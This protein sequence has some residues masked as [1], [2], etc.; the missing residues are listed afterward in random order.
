MLAVM[1]IAIASMAIAAAPGTQRRPLSKQDPVSGMLRQHNQI[2]AIRKAQRPSIPSMA[3]KAPVFLASEVSYY[4]SL[5]EITCS[6]PVGYANV[7]SNIHADGGGALVGDTYYCIERVSG[8]ILTLS[9]YDAETWEQKKSVI[10]YG[11]GYFAHDMT[12]D[13][14]DNRI[15]GC[16]MK[17]DE[18]KTG[19][20]DADFVWGYLD[21]ENESR[22]ALADMDKSLAAVAADG[23]G[24]IYA[25]DYEGIL[26]QVNKADGSLTKLAET[27]LVS[28]LATGGVIDPKSG[29]M[30]YSTQTNTV[31]PKLYSIEISTGKTNLLG[32][33]DEW[34]QL[35]GMFFP[36]PK[37]SDNAPDAPTNLQFQFHGTALMGMVTFNMPSQTY[38]GD[39]LE[40][41]LTYNLSIDGE[42]KS[43]GTGYPGE[44]V[45]AFTEIESEGQH[46]VSV[47]VSNESGTSPAIEG[48]RWFGLDQLT[49]LRK[50]NVSDEGENVTISWNAPTAVHDGYFEPEFVTYDVTRLPD[51]VKIAED[52]TGTSVSDILTDDGK[53]RITTWRV[54]V[55][56]DGEIS[57]SATSDGVI[58]GSEAEIPFRTSF[59]T[60]EE[61][62]MF[63]VINA[64]DDN[65]KWQWSSFYDM[66]QCAVL[67][68]N[69]TLAGDDW[70]IT[71]ALRMQAGKKYKVRFTAS[72]YLEWCP[73]RIEV[74]WGTA[75]I[76]EGMKD[77]LVEPTVISHNKSEAT[78]TTAIF[79]PEEDG[80]YYIGF[81]GISDPYQFY[82]IV[83]DIA[84]TESNGM[85]PGVPTELSAKADPKGA[86]AVHMSFKTPSV[87]EAGGQLSL[88]TEAVV[89]RNDNVVKTFPMPAIGSMLEFDDTDV[90][91]GF[92]TYTVYCVNN[93][94]E[95]PAATT[96]T[97][98]G[99]DVP[100]R[101]VNLKAVENSDGTVS[102]TWDA[103]STGINGGYVNSEN[104]TYTV[105]RHM[106]A[107]GSISI[108]GTTSENT[109]TDKFEAKQQTSYSYTVKASNKFGD[110]RWADSKTLVV[111]GAFDY[112]FEEHIPE[113]AT[114]NPLW[115]SEN[116]GTKG[117]WYTAAF[118]ITP[119]CHAQ[120]GDSGMFE[121]VQEKI[122][123]RA[124]LTSGNI[125]ASSAKHP[126]LTFWYYAA[127]TNN[128]TV[129][130]DADNSGWTDMAVF[131]PLQ[132][133]EQGWTKARIDLSALGATRTLRLGFLGVANEMETTIY[134][135]NIRVY[136][137]DQVNLG[138]AKAD[139]P[140]EVAAG[141]KMQAS[142]TVENTG[143]K[144]VDDATLELFR[145]E[146]NVASL[147]I[148]HIEPGET[149]VLTLEEMAL[150][151][152]NETETYRA[153]INCPGDCDGSDDQ[154][155]RY[156]NILHNF[157]FPAPGNL[158]GS[159]SG[160]KVSLNWNKPQT[161]KGSEETF[162]NYAPF[163]YAM[164]IGPWKTM[165]TNLSDKIVPV[166]NDKKGDFPTAG[167]PLG[168]Q[169][170]DAQEAGF[171]SDDLKGHNGSR[172]I[173]SFASKTGANSDWLI[174]PEVAP[175]TDVSFFAKGGNR[176]FKESFEVLYSSTDREIE[177]FQAIGDTY[178]VG[179]RWEEIKVSLPSDTKYFAICCC[180]FDC[181]A[182]VID[183]IRFFSTA[184]KASLSGYSIYC[185]GKPVGNADVSTTEWK[186]NSLSGTHQYAVTALYDLGESP[187]SNIID[188]TNA[189]IESIETG[190]SITATPDGIMIT[191][192]EGK[193][194]TVHGL[195]VIC[196][197]SATCGDRHYVTLQPGIWLISIDGNKWKIR[198]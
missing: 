14:V 2:P 146:D 155:V 92:N 104:L 50:V 187:F 102:I 166:E 153:T 162:D 180:S 19:D 68:S 26:Y 194:V 22:V 129:Q 198:F 126:V 61:F 47:T 116:E 196:L 25:L 60:K 183:D 190:I 152:F 34:Q 117:V 123:D 132:T 40:G 109:Y 139:F 85:A 174:S 29:L 115:L 140:K 106:A 3:P 113:G 185:D 160:G 150:Q 170:F 20:D 28:E 89:K 96:R 108:L 4:T 94:D 114:Q 67:K 72:C 37:A 27:G 88:I 43:E 136:D 176:Y 79:T 165:T 39:N 74:K 119:P 144:A 143:L 90:P 31:I 76:A 147:Q 65:Q 75:P 49:P 168:F 105:A 41:Q 73:E 101:V 64:N 24:A 21:V 23:K 189:G 128:L 87:T 171:T 32:D 10:V 46:T 42:P 13:P 182:L 51:G 118:G 45:Y 70:L 107:D 130:V 98:V 56:Y 112:P 48:S 111:G 6:S 133:G 197:H 157:D 8:S 195:D 17:D 161:Y 59:D 164:T 167:I 54:D 63:S 83:D 82:L 16:F 142:I 62:S 18:E 57:S 127:G 137:A 179:N 97:Y 122:G 138:I 77:T 30:Y 125:D 145:Q 163:G 86:Q 169:V 149:R 100:D 120:D 11:Y 175:G 192:A 84:I 141:C 71:P 99:E 148:G 151:S 80:L 81:H 38:S 95:G 188:I 58:R 12:Y 193:N 124:R 181:Y 156:I 159:E 5:C 184:S 35:R 172:A 69:E 1:V 154:E 121:F 33:L 15:Y 135:D 191:G 110:S 66:S 173:V 93:D 36:A 55:K 158:N 91:E 131:N 186:G 52:I 78:A 178:S 177:S 9:S 7:Q 103:A 134:I 53:L 44:M